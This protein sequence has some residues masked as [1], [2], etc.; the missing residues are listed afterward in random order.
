MPKRV[1][2]PRLLKFFPMKGIIAVV[3]GFSDMRLT[4]CLLTASDTV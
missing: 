2:L 1:R 3:V 4:P